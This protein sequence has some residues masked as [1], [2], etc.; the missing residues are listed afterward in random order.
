MPLSLCACKFLCLIYVMTLLLGVFISIHLEQEA[1]F[2]RSKHGEHA[3]PENVLPIGSIICFI[4]RNHLH[5]QSHNVRRNVLDISSVIALLFVC[6]CVC[7]FVCVF[8]CMSHT[9]SRY[10]GN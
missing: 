5:M 1:Q 7:V 8:V 6:V 2:L 4:I 3:E 10:H 9:W